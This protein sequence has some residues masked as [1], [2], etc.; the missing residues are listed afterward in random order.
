MLLELLQPEST[1]LP[2][3]LQ[4]QVHVPRSSTVMARGSAL[5]NVS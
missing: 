5:E 4:A 3:R 1:L 2:A